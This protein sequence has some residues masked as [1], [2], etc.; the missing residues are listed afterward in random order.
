MYQKASPIVNYTDINQ[1]ILKFVRA[2]G[3]HENFVKKSTKSK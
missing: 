2:T 1:E 3:K